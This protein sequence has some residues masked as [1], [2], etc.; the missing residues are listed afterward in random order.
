MPEKLE[1][2][3]PKRTISASGGFGSLQMISE[4]DTGRCVSLLTVPRRGIDTSGVPVIMLGLKWGWI[5]GGPTS[6]GGRKE[7]QRVGPEGGGL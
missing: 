6:I 7:C 5:W 2:E 1:R 4:S 3:T